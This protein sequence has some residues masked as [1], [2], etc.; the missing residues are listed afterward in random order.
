MTTGFMRPNPDAA[1][2]AVY[3]QLAAVSLGLACWVGSF[4]ERDNY[5]K[6]SIIFLAIDE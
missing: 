6:K 3:L 2:F 1:I 4:F 5:S